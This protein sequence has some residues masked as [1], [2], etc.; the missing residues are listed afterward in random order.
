MFLNLAI[1]LLF[2]AAVIAVVRPTSKLQIWLY[3]ILSPLAFAAVVCFVLAAIS[4]SRLSL[5]YKLGTAFGSCLIPILV[6]IPTLYF[7]LKKKSEVGEKYKYPSGI[8][9]AIVLL[10]IPGCISL[11]G[12]YTRGKTVRKLMEMKAEGKLDNYLNQGDKESEE[13]DESGQQGMIKAAKRF[14]DSLPEDMGNG[15]SLEKCEVDKYM[16]VYTIVWNGK[17]PSDFSENDVAKVKDSFI[18]RF[19]GGDNSS[20]LQKILE[21]SKDNGYDIM[22]K[23]QNENYDELFS[24]SILP[25]EV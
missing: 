10:A 19:K 13:V 3:S 7:I 8:F 17:H 22:I 12:D 5:D 25:Y 9:V 21:N 24:F 2:V 14:N 20:N 1:F 18:K 11:Y 6:S 23:Y 16:I 15:M 4:P